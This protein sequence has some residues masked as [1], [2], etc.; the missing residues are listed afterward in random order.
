VQF[1]LTPSF[2]GARASESGLVLPIVSSPPECW[3]DLP[4]ARGQYDFVLDPRRGEGRGRYALASVAELAA[5]RAAEGGAIR[6][7]RALGLASASLFENAYFDVNKDFALNAFNWLAER[8]Y[9][10]AVSPLARDETYLDLERGPA[11]PVLSYALLLFLPA[12]AA[13]AGG[14]VA[15]RR[16]K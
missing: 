5:T 1:V 8:E 10:L 3:R 6:K 7:G 16:R 12:L 13:L 15:W 11:R 9:R 2:E 14:F 4:D